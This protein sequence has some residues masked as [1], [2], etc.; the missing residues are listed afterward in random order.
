MSTWGCPHRCQGLVTFIA[1]VDPSAS[2]SRTFPLVSCLT[3][4]QA[5]ISVRRVGFLS[6]AY[7]RIP[8][9]RH[10]SLIASI[11]SALLRVFDAFQFTIHKSSTRPFVLMIADLRS[12]ILDFLGRWELT[13]TYRP[14]QPL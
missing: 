7:I 9:E 1:F 4:A 3:F 14:P 6:L 5:S 8:F 12:D 13:H 2:S 11:I 10:P